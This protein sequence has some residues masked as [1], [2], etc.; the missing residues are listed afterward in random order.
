MKRRV[1]SLV[2]ITMIGIL[3][4][5][6]LYLHLGGAT[7][8]NGF[9]R[10]QLPLSLKT[11]EYSNLPMNRYRIVG[12]D[13]NS[14]WLQGS[15][16]FT[17]YRY[18]ISSR[19]LDSFSLPPRSKS[20][21]TLIRYAFSIQVEYPFVY[22]FAC[23][24]HAIFRYDLITK[25]KSVFKTTRNF[26]K[27]IKIGQNTYFIREYDSQIMNQ[28]FSKY[29]FLSGTMTKERGISESKN[30]AGMPSS[31]F[32]LWDSKKNRIFF[33][34]YFGSD[35]FLLDT[36]ISLIT[37]IKTIDTFSDY[38]AEVTNTS[39][40]A[41]KSSFSYSKPR[42]I[43]NLNATF[44]GDSLYILSALKADNDSDLKFQNES[45]I[46]VYNCL[47]KQ[48]QGSY[49]FPKPNGRSMLDFRIS[50]DSLIAVYTD[51]IVFYQ[52]NHEHSR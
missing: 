26:T 40:N 43:V 13:G 47:D 12:Q 22:L 19:S 20:D 1:I 15:S 46:D 27:G 28:Y 11:L 51:K 4:L 10:Q 23:N 35:V 48:Y 2:S 37:K 7:V 42:E 45:I 30:D 6:Y 44:Y 24:L 52:F 29:D 18:G 17:I 38:H 9:M 21:S 3:I 8:P 32:P 49:Y 39:P 16:P 34:H 25:E 14:Y 41:R 36:N 31:G 5:G 50:D 33:I